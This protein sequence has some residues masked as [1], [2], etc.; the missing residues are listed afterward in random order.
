V[1]TGAFEAT[2]RR[3][4]WNKTLRAVLTVMGKENRNL[5][6]TGHNP[7]TGLQ[8]EQSGLLWEREGSAVFAMTTGWGDRRELQ[9]SL[10][11]LESFKCPE[12]L[13][14]YSCSKW[15]EAVHDQI[16]GTLLRY[17]YHIQGEQYIF[18]NLIGAENRFDLAVADVGQSG[19]QVPQND[20]LLKPV[21]GSPFGWSTK[22][23]VS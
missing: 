3:R 6:V 11:L 17:P 1:D 13:F 4:C 22:P 16:E 10:E 19:L 20:R 21:P 7:F 2:D 8:H 12:K 18:M 9:S 15:R 23:K 14:I 5:S